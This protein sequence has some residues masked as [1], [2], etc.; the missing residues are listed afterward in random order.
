MQIELKK[1][2]IVLLKNDSLAKRLQILWYEKITIIISKLYRKKSYRRR[3]TSF[4]SMLIDRVAT[5]GGK[6]KIL[7]RKSKISNESQTKIK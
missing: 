1:S 3:L 6:N 2:Q 7:T 5:Y 4:Q